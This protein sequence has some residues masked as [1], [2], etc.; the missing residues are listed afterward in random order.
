[1]SPTSKQKLHPRFSLFLKLIDEEQYDVKVFS[2]VLL[3]KQMKKLAVFLSEIKQLLSN[4]NMKN[5][6]I[7]PWTHR[8]LF[9]QRALLKVQI[10]LDLQE[11]EML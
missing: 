1:M 5:I 8:V 9:N 2:D 3:L 7:L 6:P 4:T 11:M 10:L